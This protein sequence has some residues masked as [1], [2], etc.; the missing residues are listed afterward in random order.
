MNT[1]QVGYCGQ[2]PATNVQQK[3]AYTF[4]VNDVRFSPV[5]EIPGRQ[6]RQ[7]R[8]AQVSYGP[9]ERC[10]T[11]LPSGSVVSLP[12][13]APEA[14]ATLALSGN[15]NES[16]QACRNAHLQARDSLGA[17]A[18]SSVRATTPGAGPCP[19]AARARSLTCSGRRHAWVPCQR[20]QY[21]DAVYSVWPGSA[22]GLELR[23]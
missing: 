13:D 8:A 4:A 5:N 2:N 18:L 16:S 10:R 15:S 12:D 1:N 22:D 20:K 11:I 21:R 23:P 14:V 9:L 17:G 7:I 3:L 19:R 6:I